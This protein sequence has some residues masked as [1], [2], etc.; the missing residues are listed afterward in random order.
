MC[1]WIKVTFWNVPTKNDICPIVSLLLFSFLSL[2]VLQNPWTY[3]WHWQLGNFSSASSSQW[4]IQNSIYLPTQW[5][6]FVMVILQSMF[7][8]WYNI[9]VLFELWSVWVLVSNLIRTL[10]KICPNMIIC[11]NRPRCSNFILLN[12]SLVYFLWW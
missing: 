5:Q 12:K 4:H 1:L 6:T 3:I 7:C 10:K 9:E 11:S 2:F 8:S